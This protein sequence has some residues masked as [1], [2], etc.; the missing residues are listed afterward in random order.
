MVR[1]VTTDAGYDSD[2]PFSQGVIHGDT[3]Y[4]AGQIPKDP[5]TREVIGETIE[6]QTRQ[7]FDNLEAVLEAA[8][9]SLENVVKTTA[10]L[11]DMDDIEGFNR[12]YRDRVPE[13]YPGRS[14][15]EVAALAIDITVEIEMVAA[16]E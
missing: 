9:T 8:G 10:F 1:H 15:V 11:T 12:V 3:V 4:T 7:T 13:P 14:T 2:F 5:E 16:I 6:E